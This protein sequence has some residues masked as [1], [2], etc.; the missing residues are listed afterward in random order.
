MDET[1]SATRVKSDVGWKHVEP[2]LELQAVDRLHVLASDVIHLNAAAVVQKPIGKSLRDEEQF[3]DRI[4][5]NVPPGGRE[6]IRL[7]TR[8]QLG[9]EDSAHLDIIELNSG[10]SVRVRAENSIGGVHR[11]AVDT[12]KAFPNYLPEI[13]SRE[14][15]KAD[16]GRDSKG[17]REIMP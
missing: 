6:G 14:I 12:P 15:E 17:G 10:I 9:D 11:N 5:G 3:V 7:C 4:E 16:P 1:Q 8:E 2:V 13:A